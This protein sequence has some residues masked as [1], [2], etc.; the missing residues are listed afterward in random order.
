MAEIVAEVVPGSRTSS[1]PPPPRPRT[2]RV[3]C[4]KIERRLPGFRP[5]WDARRGAE[6]LLA[7]YRGAGLTRED[8]A[9]PR[10][11]RLAHIQRLLAEGR[12]DSS[13]Y[14]T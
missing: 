8:L 14:W 9:G 6:E 2:Y 3:D 10:C 5:Q 13:L 12:L 1:S 4:S 11:K 7:A